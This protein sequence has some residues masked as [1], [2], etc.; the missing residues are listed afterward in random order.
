MLYN[1]WPKKVVLI[2]LD[3]AVDVGMSQQ[4]MS[5]V[6]VRDCKHAKNVGETSSSTSWSRKSYFVES[7]ET[8]SF[9]VALRC[10][11]SKCLWRDFLSGLCGGNDW[12]SA[13]SRRDRSMD[14]ALLEKLQNGA[15][16]VQHISDE[17]ADFAYW[18]GTYWVYCS[19]FDRGE[20][21]RRW[22]WTTRYVRS[23]RQM[24]MYFGCQITVWWFDFL[25]VICE[26]GGQALCFW[27]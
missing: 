4:V 3:L 23:T 14:F 9:D 16:C 6:I 18:F 15:D 17:S 26:C 7:V 25:V 8:A 10:C 11:L 12:W 2:W 24:T 5:D 22:Y 13:D 20:M 27:S 19:L 1:G 21:S